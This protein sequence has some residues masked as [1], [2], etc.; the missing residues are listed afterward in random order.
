MPTSAESAGLRALTKVKTPPVINYRKYVAP[1]NVYAP[2]TSGQV[3]SFFGSLSNVA[4][5]ASYQFFVLAGD[6]APQITAGFVKLNVIDRPQRKGFTVAAGY[7]PITMDVPVQFES[8][9]RQPTGKF[10][11]TNSVEHDIQ[12]LEWMAG[13]GK[14]FSAAA[15]HGV[16]APATGDPPLVQVA[17]FDSGGNETNLIPPNLHGV[18]WVIS[19]ISYD[20]NPLRTSDGN[21]ARQAATVTLTEFV[22]SPGTTLD[23]PST[24]AASR[25][26]Q[27]GKTE[28]R[29]S[30]QT[31]NTVLKMT[32]H[33]TSNQSGSTA[34]QAAQQV[35]AATKAAGVSVKSILATLPTGTKVVIPTSLVV[36]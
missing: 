36:S 24:R 28:V 4:E 20:E 3:Y 35:L 12:K 34:Q 15:D 9:V 5:V 1:P 22:A 11:I 17:S 10:A 27:T 7:D 33:Y 29:Y 30:T 26:A 13:R 31:L 23:S 14:L 16:G 8:W 18:S 21:R 32:V 6:G 25:N 2:F 19:T